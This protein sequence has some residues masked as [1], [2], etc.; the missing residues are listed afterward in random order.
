MQGSS[1]SLA[2]LR[3]LVLVN[4]GTIDSGL[5]TVIKPALKSGVK[6][7][8]QQNLHIDNPSK[9]PSEMTFAPTKGTTFAMRH[10]VIWANQ[11]TELFV[12][13][14]LCA[15]IVLS[16]ICQTIGHHF[17]QSFDTFIL[18]ANQRCHVTGCGGTLNAQTGNISSPN[19]PAS[20]PHNTECMWDINVESGYTVTL[21]FNPPF[22][23]EHHGACDF[24][25]VEVGYIFLSGGFYNRVRIL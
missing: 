8:N 15:H 4:P 13:R 6:S 21:T 7:T 19:Y 11:K 1:Y 3:G 25:F 5:T 20:Y 22:D 16:R 2:E 14:C 18:T 10:N 24:D 12:C 23:M 17:K 9:G